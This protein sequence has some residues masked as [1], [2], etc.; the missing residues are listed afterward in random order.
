[1]PGHD[2]SS[3]VSRDRGLAEVIDARFF[4]PQS[5]F[6]H[7]SLLRPTQKWPCSRHT[8]REPRYGRQ[9]A[10]HLTAARKND[11]SAETYGEPQT[12]ADPRSLAQPPISGNGS[13]MAAKAPRWIRPACG[14][15][16]PGS[17]AQ[18]YIVA[19]SPATKNSS[20]AL[21]GF[22]PPTIP[23]RWDHSERAPAQARTV[24]PA[25]LIRHLPP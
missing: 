14:H 10:G 4:A 7:Y 19:R 8:S 16:L 20:S 22:V 6:A 21:C 23:D 9:K 25:L 5:G 1:M 12:P 17:A 3:F 18:R 2:T 15:R 13:G 24:L 11:T